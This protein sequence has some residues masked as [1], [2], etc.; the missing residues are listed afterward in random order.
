MPV[1]LTVGW[2]LN[3]ALLSLLTRK[4]TV[5]P[6]SPAPWVIAVAQ[7]AVD[8]ALASSVTVWLP[9]LVKMGTALGATTLRVI[10]LGEASRSTP[11]LAVPPSS[12][13]WKVNEVYGEPVALVV[14]VKTSRPEAMFAADTTWPVVTAT[15]LSFSD[16]AAGRVV[17]FTARSELAPASSVSYMPKSAVANA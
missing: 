5:W 7:S 6:E 2:T 10:E 12:W 9:P 3:S 11:P 8:C 4:S 17:T 13:A 14:G 1:A 15:P 16:P